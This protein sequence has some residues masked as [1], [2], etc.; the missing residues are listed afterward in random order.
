ME[1]IQ[2]NP[3]FSDH[4]VLQRDA[5][6]VIWGTVKED[7]NITVSLGQVS[8]TVSA[9][10][11]K[12]RIV[13]PPM[14]AAEGLILVVSNGKEKLQIMDVAIGEVWVAGGQSNMEFWMRYEKHYQETLSSCDNPNIRFFDMPK[15]AYDGQEN[16]FDYHNVGIWRK[17]DKRNLEYFSAIGYYLARELE[18]EL[19]VPIGVIGCNWG[20]TRSLAWM[21]EEHAREIQKEQTADFYAKLNGQSYEEFCRTAGEN[22]MNDTG[23]SVWNPFND[24]ILPKTPSE[25]E[26]H[27]F[28]AQDADISQIREMA[29]PQD[30]PGH[31]IG[32]WYKGSHHI[33]YGQC[34]G[35]RGKATMQS[36]ERRKIIR[37]LWMQ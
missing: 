27:I 11:G 1:N 14:P 8:E 7:C 32:I 15:L 35:I 16:D 4:M 20:G 5:D 33:R 19:E 10:E 22:P 23:N 6:I 2:L 24:F 28:T 13:L 25:E 18:K 30:A 36:T 9:K 29:K 26:I 31:Y 12:W 3:I 21:K 17:A 34:S 37:L